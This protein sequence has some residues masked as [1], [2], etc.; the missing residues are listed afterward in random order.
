[1]GHPTRRAKIGY[2]PTVAR[3]F[4]SGISFLFMCAFCF[5]F[6]RLLYFWLCF[7]NDIGG[8]LRSSG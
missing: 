5:S 2:H 7:W 4:R 3:F 1:M 6:L 8:C